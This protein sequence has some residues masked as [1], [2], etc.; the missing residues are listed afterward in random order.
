MTGKADGHA[1]LALPLKTV[2]SG[3]VHLVLFGLARGQT[4]GDLTRGVVF[5]G[6]DELQ[7]R[8]L[9]RISAATPARMA[10]DLRPC[11]LNLPDEPIAPGIHALALARA[12]GKPRRLR[13]EVIECLSIPIHIKIES[14]GNIDLVE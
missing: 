11:L 10:A 6:D 13:I 4:L 14:R 5:L 8:L 2:D 9:S 7:K 3:V 12:H 1:L